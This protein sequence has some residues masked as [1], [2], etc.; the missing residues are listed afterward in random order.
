MNRYFDIQL[1]W[2]DEDRVFSALVTDFDEYDPVRDDDIFW[3]GLS[4]NEIQHHI[5]TGEPVCN[6]FVILSYEEVKH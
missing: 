3:H 2:I 5:R 6:Q 1:K 4:E